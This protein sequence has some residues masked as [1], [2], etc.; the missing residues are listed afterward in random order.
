[1]ATISPCELQI[2]SA[3]PCLANGTLGTPQVGNIY[4]L[5]VA[6]NVRGTPAR[7]FRI[8]WTIANVTNYDDNIGVGPGS[9]YQLY[10]TW[11]LSLDDLIPWSVTLDPDGI[12][13][14]TNLAD[15]IFS[16]VFTP[17]P[18]TNAVELYAPLTMGG[19]ET[20]IL[21]FQPG[22]GT[23][24]NLWVVF[25]SPTSH[26]AQKVI[27]VTGPSNAVSIVTS[28]YGIPVF[29]IAWSNTPAATFRECETF[30]AQLSNMRVNPNLLRL[31]TWSQMNSLST[32]WSQWLAPD[33]MVESTNSQITA[34]VQESLPTNFLTILTPYDTARTLHLAVM[35][36]L[37]YQ[38]PPPYGDAVNVLDAGVADCG[39][40]AALLAACLRNVGIPARR[41]SGFWQGDSW[42]GD[43]QWHVRVEFYLPSV[44][45]LVAD[46]TS[47]NAN[48]PSGTYAYDFAFVPDANQYFAV[49]SVT[50]M[51]CPI[52]TSPNSRFQTLFGMVA[53]HSILTRPSH[54]FSRLIACASQTSAAVFS[55]CH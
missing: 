38:S 27:S 12:T 3:G 49:T 6:F 37:T 31:A 52:I 50:P 22:S 55:I 1:M 17:V 41:I 11:F 32:N 35:K 21:S 39:G 34:F 46:P 13:G 45:W 20:S 42:Q 47:G 5:S 26:G 28:P 18:P 19:I 53:P 8:K 16:G 33:Q 30:T 29:A 15:T 23:I 10:F 7:P 4:G 44:G 24:P 36:K 43:I 51:F 9:G 40:F 25:G 48:D 14:N 54:I 2:T